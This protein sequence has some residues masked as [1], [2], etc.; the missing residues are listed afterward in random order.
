MRQALGGF[1]V[2]TW[3][4]TPC[5]GESA[6]RLT[7]ASATAR[8]HGML[9]GDALMEFLMMYRDDGTASYVGLHRITGQL[10]GRAGTFAI[11]ERGVFD[12][13]TS[14][15]EWT[16]VSGSGTNELAGLRGSGSA[17]AKSPTES[18]YHLDYELAS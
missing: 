7:R 16:V 2:K 10:G 11:Q 1:E 8:V 12:G 6:L 5:A 17:K 3:D 14:H 4:E 13:T 15:G 18:M 9:E